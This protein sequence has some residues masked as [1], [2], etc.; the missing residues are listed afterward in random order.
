MDEAV[1]LANKVEEAI[2]Q[3][4]S[5]KSLDAALETLYPLEKQTRLVSLFCTHSRPIRLLMWS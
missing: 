3:A 2:K 5:L 4:I 1:L